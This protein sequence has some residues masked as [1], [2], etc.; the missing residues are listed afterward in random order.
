[1]K[2]H[3][4]FLFLLFFL[5]LSGSAAADTSGVQ[6]VVLY[7]SSR[8]QPLS[9]DEQALEGFRAD[10][11][12]DYIRE[13]KAS[14]GWFERIL[15]WL[16]SKLFGN[17]NVETTYNVLYNSFM[18]VILPLT[19][20]FIIWKLIGADRMSLFYRKKA[21]SVRVQEEIEDIR[22]VDLNAIVEEAIKNEDYKKA[23]RYSYL[24][25]LKELAEKGIIEWSS[26]K[27][28]Y[29]YLKEIK[30][31]EVKDAFRDATRIFEYCWYGDIPLTK[32]SFTQARTSFQLISTGIKDKQ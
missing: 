6:Q 22:E 4:N 24:L 32:E 25:L 11:D 14:I 31:N 2:R 3:I 5:V 7:D 30:L 16:L 8:I 13:N 17:T 15:F 9:F 21:K 12:F 1:M 27:T 23:V 29:D 20:L 19:I 18:Y 10:S 26:A 28:N